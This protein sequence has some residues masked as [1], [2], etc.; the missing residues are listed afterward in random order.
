[1]SDTQIVTGLSILASGFSQINCGFS[2]FHLHMVVFLAWFSSVTH[3]T[4]LTFLRR[5]IHDN[6]GI[7]TL[8]LILMMLLV[9][10]L[11][12]A[13]APTG[14]ACGL[15]NAGQYNYTLT[16]VSNSPNSSNWYST[17]EAVFPGS[18]AKCCFLEMHDYATFIGSDNTYFISMITS[19]VVLISSSF[20]RVMK[21]F[22]GSSDFAKRWLRHKPA[23]MCKR[24]A[25]K[26]E[27]RYNNPNLKTTQRINFLSHCAI[28]VFIVFARAIYDLAESMLWE[29]C[30]LDAVF[31][32]IS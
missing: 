20:T 18:P 12:V 21:L 10:T 16:T 2:I 4:T 11:A 24:I 6:H 30:R 5:H 3:L 26:F 28:M 15:Q 13:L 8:R 1:M 14:G 23:Q 19:E 31:C 32:C 27:E 17:P 29:V 25:R 22:R 7:R 9:V